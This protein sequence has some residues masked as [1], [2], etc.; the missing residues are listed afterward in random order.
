M[1]NTFFLIIC[2]LGTTFTGCLDSLPFG[3]DDEEQTP[4][5]LV[6]DI[7][8]TIGKGDASSFCNYRLGEYGYPLEEDAKNQCKMSSKESAS[9]LEYDVNYKHEYEILEVEEIG[10]PTNPKWNPEIQQIYRLNISY[11]PCLRNNADEMWNCEGTYL[12]SQIIKM[13]SSS[14]LYFSSIFNYQPPSASFFVSKASNGEYRVDIM[15][16]TGSFNLSDVQFRLLKTDGSIFTN[17]NH[18]EYNEVAMKFIDGV[19]YGIDVNYGGDDERLRNRASKVSDDHNEFPVY[20]SDNDRNSKLSV[21]D[22]FVAVGPDAGPVEDGWKLVI[23]YNYAHMIE[24]GT[25]N[26]I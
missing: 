1:R 25:V 26:F 16:V 12:T 20:F 24:I 4:S 7:M 6:S 19:D 15:A 10:A 22:R 11:I 17:S 2:L 8:N 23:F 18:S 9:T 14:N 3:E 5:S 13:K 21:N